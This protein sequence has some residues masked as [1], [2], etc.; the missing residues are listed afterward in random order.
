MLGPRT[1][2]LRLSRDDR[3][4]GHPGHAHTAETQTP[5]CKMSNL[6]HRERNSFIKNFSKKFLKTFYTFS[7]KFSWGTMGLGSGIAEDVAQVTTA[8]R[9]QSG[10][11]TS[12]YYGC[13]QKNNKLVLLATAKASP[14]PVPSRSKSHIDHI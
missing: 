1:S 2:S 4:S 9:V 6:S 10:L 11:G 3:G 13:S 8:A 12:P 5:N 14:M 7:K